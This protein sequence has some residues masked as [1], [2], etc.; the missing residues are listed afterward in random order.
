MSKSGYDFVS[1]LGIT[2]STSRKKNKIR[3]EV[4]IEEVNKSID[5]YLG[6]ESADGRQGVLI[7]MMED[8]TSAH[9]QWYLRIILKD[10]KLGLD[11]T[12]ILKK[13]HPD[14]PKML[15]KVG[16]SNVCTELLNPKER[17]V[18]KVEPFVPFAPMI[19]TTKRTPFVKTTMNEFVLE[20]KKN[21]YKV[22]LHFDKFG[23]KGN[24]RIELYSDSLNDVSLQYLPPFEDVVVNAI[25]ATRCIIEGEILAWDGDQEC[26]IHPSKMKCTVKAS[27]GKERKE[28]YKK[29]CF[30]ASDILYLEQKNKKTTG[31]ILGYSLRKRRTILEKAVKQIPK[32]FQVLQQTRIK[33]IDDEGHQH[34]AINAA[35]ESMIDNH[36]DELVIKDL[37]SPYLPGQR[38][39]KWVKLSPQYLDMLRDYS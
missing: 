6:F 17:C 14:A 36:L 1:D 20:E 15:K 37:D 35:F 23:E 12:A 4:S 25:K 7:Q 16:L 31:S 28:H 29:F 21:G 8:L 30:F 33:H 24:P 5:M 38:S 2:L 32:R 11:S 18:V 9:F 39:E 3:E 13:F 27:S 22:L 19:P 34:A 26:F 10:L